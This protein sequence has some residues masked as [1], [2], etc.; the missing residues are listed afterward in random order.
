MSGL[1]PLQKRQRNSLGQ[2]DTGG[3][4]GDRDAHAHNALGGQAGDGHKAT[5]IL[6]YQIEYELA[7]QTAEWSSL[8]P[9]ASWDEGQL[10]SDC[11]D[12]LAGSLFYARCTI[13]G[14]RSLIDGVAT[15]CMIAR[16][17]IRK[18]SRTR[19]TPG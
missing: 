3:Q 7:L 12:Q 16:V 14:V 2:K 5:H 8:S 11:Q 4:V 1:R 9:S 13:A 19:S 15:C 17:S 6:G 18:T 10:S